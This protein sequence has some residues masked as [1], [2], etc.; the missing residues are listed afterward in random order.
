LVLGCFVAT[1]AQQDTTK[2]VGIVGGLNVAYLGGDETGLV[3]R[4]LFHVGAHLQ[5]PIS[6]NLSWRAGLMYSMQGARDEE[7]NDQKIGYGY[8]AV[9]VAMQ[10]GFYKK[11]HLVVGAQA[12]YLVHAESF[13]PPV[14]TQD[15]K[16]DLNRMDFSL[17]LEGNVRLLPQYSFGARYLFGINATSKNAPA[18]N[19]RFPNRVFQFSFTRH[20][21]LPPKE[22]N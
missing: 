9:P 4:L 22:K 11:Y 3:P 17:I 2:V 18:K 14:N 12:A 16:D 6:S 10:M 1:M 7:M 5:Q 19:T 15:I 20:I 8:L 13:F 21:A